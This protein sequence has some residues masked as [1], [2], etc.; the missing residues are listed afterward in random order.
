MA[1]RPGP[2]RQ[3]E[4][5]RL[6]WKQVDILGSTMGSDAEFAAMLDLVSTHEITP[7]VDRVYPLAEAGAAQARMEEAGQFGKIVLDV[8]G[9][10]TAAAL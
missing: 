10:G 4:L 3:L 8:A 5:T 9:R 1:R 2:S 7:A 6:F